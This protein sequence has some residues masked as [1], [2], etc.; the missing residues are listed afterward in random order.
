MEHKGTKVIETERL[1]L[2]PFQTEDAGAMFRNWANDPEVTK[3]L[4]WPIHGDVSV[5]GEILEDWIGRYEEPSYYQW[6]IE[7]KEIHEPIGSISAV[8]VDDKTESATV[9][10]CIGRRFWGQ[11]ITAEA[12]GAVVAFFFDQVGMNCVNACHDPHNPNSGKVMRKCGMTWEGT[13]RARGI[14]N[15]GRCDEC[16]YSILKEEYD[17]RTDA[18]N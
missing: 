2:R 1:V 8:K 4:T 3:F 13:W 12:L 6:A 7:L 18:E 5:S 10:Y 9:G 15:Q 11:G 16:W 14:N 17:R